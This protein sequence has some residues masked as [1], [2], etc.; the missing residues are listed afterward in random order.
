MT[1]CTTYVSQIK[2]YILTGST[3][4]N[5]HFS[6]WS[7][8]KM[9]TSQNVH[10]ANFFLCSPYCAGVCILNLNAFCSIPLDLRRTVYCVALSRGSVTHWRF[11]LARMQRTN[12]AAARDQL[13]GALACTRELW[14]LTQ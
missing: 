12:V 10:F 1:F 5:M 9:R 8:R 4:H 14:I 7:L 2:Y 6:K 3:S 13:L 11:A